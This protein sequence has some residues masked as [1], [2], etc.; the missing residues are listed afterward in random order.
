MKKKHIILISIGIFLAW[1]LSAVLIV[2]FVDKDFRGAA[3]DLFGAVNALFSGL[4]FAGLI[5]TIVLQ[6]GDLDLQR[7]AIEMQTEEMK[8]QKAEAARSADQLEQ[9]RKLLDYQLAIAHVNELI[10]LKNRKIDYIKYNVVN[11][12]EKKLYTGIVAL[13]EFLKRGGLESDPEGA[14]IGTYEFIKVFYFTLNYIESS[15]LDEEFKEELWDLVVLEISTT[16]HEVINSVSQQIKNKPSLLEKYNLK[17]NEQILIYES[18][19]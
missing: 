19:K 1:A 12:G 2:I 7:K 13:N 8:G 4:A 15:D 17:A 16:E 18:A 10:N 14:F 5:I 6:R 3:G 9:Q 11:K